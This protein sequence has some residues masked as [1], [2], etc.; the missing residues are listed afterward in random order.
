MFL[1]AQTGIA[2]IGAAGLGR[3]SE[4]RPA[5]PSQQS[6]YRMKAAR[7]NRS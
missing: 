5:N 6:H 3:T 4:R 1:P 2:E 7:Y